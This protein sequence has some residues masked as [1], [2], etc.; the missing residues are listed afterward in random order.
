MYRHVAPAQHDLTLG[1]GEFFQRAFADRAGVGV[2]RQ[3]HH[4]DGI[5]VARGQVEAQAIGFGA[6]Q[7]M[8]DLNQYARAVAGQR[9]RADGATM[10]Q[11]TQNLQPIG[12]DLMALLVFDLRDKTDAAGVMLVP[13]IV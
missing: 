8:R 10:F 2:L 12:H 13:W 4:A 5:V 7:A 6:K 1:A 9:V 11:I 3:E